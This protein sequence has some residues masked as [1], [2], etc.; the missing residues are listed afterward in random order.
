MACER[1]ERRVVLEGAAAAAAK[2]QHGLTKQRV[3]L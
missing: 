2:V 3:G 1:Q